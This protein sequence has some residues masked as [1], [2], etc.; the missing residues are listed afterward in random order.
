VIKYVKPSWLRPGHKIGLAVSA[1]VVLGLVSYKVI[2]HVQ[3]SSPAVQAATVKRPPCS[4]PFHPGIFSSGNIAENNQ[5]GLDARG[6]TLPK[7]TSS[8]DT[9]RNGGAMVEADKVSKAD[10]LR[11]P[12]HVNTDSGA[13]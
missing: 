2:V 12:G 7:V 3:N 1:L 13:M 5:T 11:I 6:N 9:A 10:L 8:N 4:T